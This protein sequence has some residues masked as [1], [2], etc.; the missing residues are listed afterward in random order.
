[1]TTITRLARGFPVGLLVLMSGAAWTQTTTFLPLTDDTWVKQSEPDRTNGDHPRIA[2]GAGPKEGLVRFDAA[3]IAGQHISRATLQLFLADLETPGPLK[4]GAA[5]T[6][7]NEDTVTWATRPNQGTPVSVR[8]T[9]SDVGF[10]VAI[11]VTATVQEWAD[12]TRPDAGFRLSTDGFTPLIL[13]HSKET[14]GGN[15]PMLEVVTGGAPPV[16]QPT[17]LDLSEL[18]VVI[19]EPGTYVLDRD[20]DLGTLATPTAIDV[21]ARGAIL[22]MRGFAIRGRWPI[23][24]APGNALVMT[25]GDGSFP[26]GTGP[27]LRN[28]RLEASPAVAGD[29]AVLE[30]MTIRGSPA[31][32]FEDQR[33]PVIGQSRVFGPVLLGYFALVE[34]SVFECSGLCIA[35]DDGVTFLDNFVFVT[36]PSPESGPFKGPVGGLSM[37]GRGVVKDNRMTGSDGPEFMIRAAG[38]GSVIANNVFGV[39]I[40][41]G[42]GIIVDG[43]RNIIQGN[44]AGVI[45][46]LQDGNFYSDNEGVVELLGTEQIDGGGNWNWQGIPPLP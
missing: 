36:Y 21:Q 1:M 38:S 18:P 31:I 12:G 45:R 16:G 4:V 22:D 35:A 40:P 24:N 17:V 23:P 25:R 41:G 42:A 27:V 15:A 9:L 28:G 13:L 32:D 30:K 14:S 2:I 26:F 37:S 19:D 43:N 33:G 10:Y 29:G 34:N 46:F 6:S 5:N 20:W 11:D 39:P 7:W 3:S 8:V 44:K